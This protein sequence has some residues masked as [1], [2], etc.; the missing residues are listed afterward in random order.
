MS[1][2]MSRSRRAEGKKGVLGCE[3]ALPAAESFGD[4]LSLGG[5]AKG[6]GLDIDSVRKAFRPDPRSHWKGTW[7]SSIDE[8]HD[9]VYWKDILCNDTESRIRARYSDVS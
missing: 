2:V 9:C 7:K 8:T 5:L 4:Y 1:S 3:D 6:K